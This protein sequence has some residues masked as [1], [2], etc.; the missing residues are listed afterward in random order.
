[1]SQSSFLIAMGSHLVWFWGGVLAPDG[2]QTRLRRI[3]VAC[4]DLSL[5]KSTAH[6]SQTVNNGRL[7]NTTNA[8]PFDRVKAS[9]AH[10]YSQAL[11]RGTAQWKVSSSAG[12]RLDRGRLADPCCAHST[13]KK[14]QREHGETKMAC[15][16][17][18]RATT[19]SVGSCDSRPA[20][21][22]SRHRRPGLSLK[23][24]K[25]KERVRNANRN[26]RSR[27]RSLIHG[28]GTFSTSKLAVGVAVGGPWGLS[29]RVVLNTNHLRS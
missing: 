27:G 11:G 24:K 2:G 9:D 10:E 16:H 1:M 4:I 12:V 20:P 19:M 23:A 14:H 29:F 5:A 28:H 25:K 22:S 8:T 7:S 3:K 15:N 6:G 17:H 26:E 13:P 21:V 18:Q